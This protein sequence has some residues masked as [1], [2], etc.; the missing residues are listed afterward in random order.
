MTSNAQRAPLTYHARYESQSVPLTGSA[1]GG[2]TDTTD[3]ALYSTVWYST[4][5]WSM[6]TPVTASYRAPVSARSP[7]L[8]SVSRIR[9]A[10]RSIMGSPTCACSKSSR[11]VM[12]PSSNMNW[13]ES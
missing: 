6:A 9:N 1:S 3:S 12:R 7:M 4:T 10:A 8:L 11:P 2:P 5:S 13:N